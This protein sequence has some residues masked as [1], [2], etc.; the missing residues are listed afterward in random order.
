MFSLII[1]IV[2]IALVAALALATLYYGGKAFEQSTAEAQASK[3]VNQGQQLLGAAELYYAEKG[4]WPDTLD[5]L[6]SSNYLKKV[7]VAQA[8][9]TQALAENAW[10]MPVAREPLFLLNTPDAEPCRGVNLKSYGQPGILPVIKSNLVMQCYGKSETELVTIVAR[11]PKNLEIAANAIAAGF[12]PADVSSDPLPD[13]TG[14]AGWL[15]AP[16]ADAQP[17]SPGAG[18]GPGGSGPTEPEPSPAF[19]ALEPDSVLFGSVANHTTATQVLTLV[20]RGGSPLPLDPMA[21]LTGSAAFAQLSTTC[22]TSL[23]PAISCEIT[24]TYSPVNLGEETAQLTLRTGSPLTDTVVQVSATSYNPVSL[25]SATLPNAQVSK[26]YPGFD[27][28]TVLSVSNESTP[29][30]GAVTWSTTGNVPAGLSV[31]SS[32]VLGGT[33]TQASVAAGASFEVLATYKD[34]T[35]QQVYT[36]KVAD[37]LLDVK[38]ISSGENHTCAVTTSG[39]AKCWGLNS[40]GQLGNS[41]TTNS[42]RPVPVTGL[43]SGVAV[44]SAGSSFSCAVDVIGQTFC[45]GNNTYG[46]LGDGGTTSRANPGPVSGLGSGVGS[47]VEAGLT[48]ACAI[49]TGGEMRCWGRNNE[50]QLGRGNTTNSVTP[51]QVTGM[52]SGVT[53]MG[54]RKT[55]TGA[56]CAVQSGAAKCWGWNENN[57]LGDGS[58]AN[59]V[60]SSPLPVVGLSSGVTAIQMGRQHT[61]AIQSGGIK[62]W[63]DN[64][65]GQHGVGTT[66]GNTPRSPNG[67]TANI[68]ALALGMDHVCAV[69]SGAAKCWGRNANGQLGDNSTTSRNVPTD[70]VGLSSGVARITAGNEFS[71]AHTSEGVKCWGLNGNGQIGDATNTQRLAP[72]GVLP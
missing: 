1:T 26:A 8:A 62:C 13:P 15:I 70:V 55:S 24:L 7:P 72:A 46:Q 27:F 3:I 66:P 69:Q 40:S 39:A 67:M 9:V 17:V 58:Q 65:F 31:S 53:A 32:G 43:G 44:I 20:N 18:G 2:S 4:Q 25:G 61:C 36:I 42:N 45:W 12:D 50:G 60:K 23:A 19:L 22:G 11:N 48:H 57:S 34:N 41:T 54:L 10:R 16:G 29:D 6:V 52:S 56:T 5:D 63:G 33:P 71:C 35:G 68:S 51:V 30:L 21:T 49:T 37:A 28:K 14:T 59:E 47:K 64:S 38:Y